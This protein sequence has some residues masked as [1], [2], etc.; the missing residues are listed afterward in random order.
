MRV[1]FKKCVEVGAQRRHADRDTV[2]RAVGRHEGVSGDA[3]ETTLL[4]RGV[5]CGG[6]GS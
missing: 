1:Q 4:E 5:I 3:D 2:A 6:R